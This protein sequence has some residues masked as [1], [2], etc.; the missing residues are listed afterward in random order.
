[1][2]PTHTAD[3]I[4][5]LRQASS[6]ATERFLAEHQ[7]QV[8]QFRESL[9]AA[10]QTA[11]ARL[12]RDVADISGGSNVCT[13][14]VD[15]ATTYVDWL[16]W[17]LWDLPY[18]AV[19]LD[20]DP[21]TFGARVA[22]CAFI[23][24]SGRI[25]DD[26]IDRHFWYKAK[27]P[28]LLSFTANGDR[29]GEPADGLTVLAGLLLC[30]DGLRQ[31]SRSTAD[32]SQL[33]LRKVLDAFRRAVIG[34]I[35]EHEDRDKWD[36]AYYER[37]V[38][39]KNVDFWRCLYSSIDPG[40]VSPLYPFL[41][42]YYTFAQKLN[43]VQDFAED[44]TRGQPNLLSVRFQT[45]DGAA[46]PFAEVAADLSDALLRL[47]R[48]AAE[49]P[50]VEQEVALL[51]LGETLRE[52][53]KLGIVDSPAEEQAQPAQA[54]RRSAPLGLE[55][56]STLTDV[57][58]AAGPEMIEAADCAI[59]GASQ[60][61]RLFS[62]RGFSY[63][64]CLEC[65]HIYTSP[66][67]RGELQLLL[68]EDL[69]EQ[70]D[71]NEF[72]EVQRIFAEPICSLLRMRAPGPRLLDIGFGRGHILRL[73]RAYG[74]E[75]YGI[76]SSEKSVHQ[77]EPEFGMRVHAAS[78]GV[79]RIPWDSFDAI[80][81][82]HVIEH[83]TDPA[84]ILADIALRLRPGGLLYVAVPDMESVQFRLF[85]KHWDVISP[86]VHYQYFN[87][88]SL[89]RLLTDCGFEA[90]ER[91]K[92]P[93]LPRELTPKWMQLLRKLGGDESGELAMVAQKPGGPGA[94]A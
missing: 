12:K 60:R 90:L 16:Q 59:C 77:L 85:G 74:F 40:R 31:L 27:Q 23:Y 51:K 48:Q 62:L 35:L 63:H 79:D 49:L 13:Q 68:G 55:W 66:R 38:R 92:F 58:E 4:A 26:V 7:A 61:R 5:E 36:P 89:S 41:E 11:S 80:V 21:Q 75:A 82:S 33:R 24:L 67:P 8:E 71:D 3:E 39:L 70:E 64:R 14:L 56:Y 76:D 25:F 46:S 78:L 30:S 28:T 81:M 86:L 69:E 1:M 43:D 65:D 42:Q 91:I 22:D 34:A 47:R 6:Q 32:D 17:S 37:L 94:V 45:A 83:L 9:S 15:Q 50:P 18:F 84:A 19:P 73:A 93:A 57:V 72:L 53:V 20:L 88:S 2:S 87:E 29:A 54:T 10:M 52:A 44:E